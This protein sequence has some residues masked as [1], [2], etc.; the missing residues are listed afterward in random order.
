MDI[1]RRDFLITLARHYYEEDLSQQEIADRYTISRSNVS[2]LLKACKEEKI[3]E[4]RI[5]APS[6]QA[7]QL[8]TRLMETF[9][10]EQAIIAPSGPDL[11]TTK[12]ETARAGASYLAALLKDSM[13]IGISW[14]TTLHRLVEEFHPRELTGVEVIQ[15]HGGFGAKNPEIDGHELAGA[16]AKKL[17]G[18]Y[19]VIQAPAIVKNQALRD[20][21]LGEPNIAEVVALAGTVHIALM[22]IGSNL[23]EISSMVRA[24]YLTEA[25]SAELIEKGAIGV[26]CGLHFD[27]QGNMLSLPINDKHLGL[28]PE[29]LLAIPKRFGVAAGSKKIGPILAALS[30]GLINILITDEQT[31]MG[32]LYHHESDT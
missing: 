25:E 5:Q 4:I 16:L 20:L 9:G 17:R 3:V 18:A 10:L 30:G 19:R 1:T 13:K 32:I 26:T 21:L 11:E 7:L 24:G 6:S 27:K 22:G 14:G 23:P 31:A 28:S 29:A 15:L 12:T 2:K 8:K